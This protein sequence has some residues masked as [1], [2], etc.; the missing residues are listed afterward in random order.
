MQYSV[1]NHQ[2]PLSE[3]ADTPFKFGVSLPERVRWIVMDQMLKRDWTM[4][5]LARATC[6]DQEY[7]EQTMLGGRDFTLEDFAAFMFVLDLDFR[8]GLVPKAE[9]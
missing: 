1:S 9:S 4:E 8:F 5:D 7:I 6:F 2:L 3:R